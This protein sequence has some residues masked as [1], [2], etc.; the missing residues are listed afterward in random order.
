MPRRLSYNV[1]QCLEKSRDSALLS[2]ET[3]NKPAIKFRSGGYIVLMIIAWTSLF[4]AI[5]FKQKVKPFYR[6]KGK[7]KFEKKDDDYHYWELKTCIKE[8]FKDDTQNPIRRNLEFFIPLRNKIEHRSIPEIDPDLFA[9]CQALLLNYDK[10]LEKEFGIDYCIRESLSFSLQLFP[11]SRSL[12]E[13]VKF[14]PD[15][16]KIR[17]FIN[18]YRSALSTDILESGQYSFKAFLIQVVNHKSTDTLPIQ[19]VRYDNLTDEE[20]RNLNRMVAMVKFQEKPV[21]H[22]NLM[23]PADV[24][25]QVQSALNDQKIIRKNNKPKD[26]FNQDTHTRC[27]KKYQVRPNAKDKSPHNTNSKYCI[28]DKL[29]SQYGYTQEWVN[30]LIEKMQDEEEYNSLYNS[31]INNP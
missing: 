1:K 13:A 23:L 29:T 11:S 27:W 26:K 6:E 25:K 21:V 19:F 31:K 2:V 12:A 18:K 15:A 4:H 8:Y 10:T 16:K 28:Y 24:V 20:K 14:N 17:E 9:E 30:F 3:Y 5:F 7:K 22:N